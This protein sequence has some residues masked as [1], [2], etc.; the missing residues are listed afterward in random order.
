M[1]PPPRPPPAQVGGVAAPRARV[2]SRFLESIHINWHISGIAL[3][4]ELLSLWSQTPPWGRMPAFLV[5]WPCTKYI[6]IG[7]HIDV[8]LPVQQQPR[9]IILQQHRAR[10]LIVPPR[11]FT[12]IR[13]PTASVLVS[14]SHVSRASFFSGLHQDERLQTD[15]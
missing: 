12:F 5:S 3:A 14:L 2:K 8:T 15:E 1:Y 13:R 6:T 7:T 9:L 4:A 10:A 11:L